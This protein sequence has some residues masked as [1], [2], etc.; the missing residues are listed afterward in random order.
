MAQPDFYAPDFVDDNTPEEIQERMMGSL[1][2]DI[3]DMPGGFP[4]DFTMPSAIE[5]SELINFHLVRA[6][7]IAFPQYAWGEWLDLHGRQVNVI[8][9]EAFPARGVLRLEGEAGTKIEAGTV[10][11]V[12]AVDDASAVEYETEEDCM[13]DE[14]GVAEV[15][16]TAVEA[17][18]NGNVK[19]GAVSIMDEPV[20]E[21]TGITNPE[22]LQGGA[23]AESD[24]DYYDRIAAE[25]ES[26]RTYLGNDNDFI[27]W[28]K[29]AGAGDCIVDAA[30]NGPGTVKLVLVD[31]NGQPAD[32]AL[33]RK[34][35]EHIVSPDDRAARLLP[36][37]CAD[38][39]CVAAA[40]VKIHYSCTGLQHDSTTDIGQIEENFRDALKLLY[41]EAKRKGTLRY[42]D[43]RPV[44]SRIEGVEDFDS[45]LING[46][47][48]NILFRSEEYPETG[49]CE[50]C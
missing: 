41:V 23:E 16:I 38:L 40:T 20:D 13:I 31:V 28:A 46:D 26:S 10:F 33:V 15:G 49:E 2:E 6:L 12:P 27:R 44:I 22:A 37:A 18:I 50:F 19:A 17:G 24:D 29:E 1:P 14:E 47:M 8:R 7:M 45:F 43:V 35:Y 9:H 34:V 42:N 30:W 36:T 5:K 39:T 48:K 32:D 3:D 11:C 25:Y 21:V 4:Y